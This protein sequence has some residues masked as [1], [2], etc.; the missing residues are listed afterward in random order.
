VPKAHLPL[1]NMPI[2]GLRNQHGTGSG[3]PGETMKDG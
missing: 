2:A 3:A 1:G